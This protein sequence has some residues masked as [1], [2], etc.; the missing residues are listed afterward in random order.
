MLRQFGR[1]SVGAVR[2]YVRHNASRAAF[3][4]Q[5]TNDRNGS[6]GGQGFKLAIAALPIA[7]LLAASELFSKKADNCGIVGKCFTVL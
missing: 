4:S 5:Q 7:A 2:N 6:S 3:A 1:K